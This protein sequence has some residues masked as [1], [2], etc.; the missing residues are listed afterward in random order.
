M[1]PLD[2]AEVQGADRTLAEQR[3]DVGLDPALVHR[4]R[5][6]LDRPAAAADDPASLRFG[7]IPVA[8]RGN[9]RL[10]RPRLR[11]QLWIDPLGDRGE[12]VPGGIACLL[13]RHQAVAADDGTAVAS[14]GRPVLDDEALEAGGTDA[15]TEAPEFAVPE[16]A[17]KTLDPNRRRF[18]SIDA[19]LCQ[20]FHLNSYI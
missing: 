11:Q 12:D 14:L 9:G 13:G 5:R 16:E 3:L 6:R 18:Q 1:R 4:Q 8:E 7:Q 19:A 20:F 17:F 2:V 10:L 15:H